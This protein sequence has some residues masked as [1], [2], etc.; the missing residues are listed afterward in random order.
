MTAG[1]IEIIRP[2]QISQRGEIDAT[3]YNRFISYLNVRPASLATYSRCL[4]QLFSYF[5]EHNIKQPSRDDIVMFER[6][7]LNTGHK[8]TTIQT[9]LTSAKLFFQW[10]EREGIYSNVM[11]RYKAIERPDKEHKKDSFTA[12]DIKKILA[13]IDRTTATGRRDYAIIAL[14][15]S[16]GLRT[17]EASRADVKDLRTV[18]D[19]TVIYIQGKG[20]SDKADFV[21]ISDKTAAA[22]REYLAERGAKPDEPLFISS[23]NRTGG[24]RLAT[25]SISE[26]IKNRF[27]AAGYISDKLTAHSLRHT[28][29]TLSLLAGKSLDEV[30]QMARHANINTTLIY[31][32][33][34]DK[35][36]NTCSDAISEA[37]F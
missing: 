31:S 13:S 34:I 4:K 15:T 3:L 14:L 37:I 33:A 17:I 19:A 23:S 29:V 30:Q 28:A 1:Q 7:L 9:Y 20:R 21:K 12:S 11:D 2:D 32:H 8:A 16:A 22:V 24:N 25:R 10:T 5:A 36:R 27:K 6:G 35:A 26:I 18:G